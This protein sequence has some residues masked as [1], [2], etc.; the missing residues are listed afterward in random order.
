M[1]SAAEALSTVAR[2][3]AGADYRAASPVILQLMCNNVPIAQ[4]S[5]RSGEISEP[6][7]RAAKTNPLPYITEHALKVDLSAPDTGRCGSRV[8]HRRPIRSPTSN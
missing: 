6:S 5:R 8:R 1:V 4:P 3:L 7:D 2:D